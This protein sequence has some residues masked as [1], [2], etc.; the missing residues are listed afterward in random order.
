MKSGG[1]E[2]ISEAFYDLEN[3]PEQIK[4]GWFNWF[5]EY[6]N[7]LQTESSNDVAR[8]KAMTQVNPKY[9]LRNYMAQLAIDEADKGNFTLIDELFQLLKSPM[10][11]S[12]K[13]TN[14]LPSVQIGHATKWVALCYLAV[15]KNY[16]LF[17]LL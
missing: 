3:L 12:Q 6:D 13:I 8:S 17:L 16:S 5:Q 15:L 4:M 14:G 9:V 1:L 11:S 2:L 10:Q 7:R